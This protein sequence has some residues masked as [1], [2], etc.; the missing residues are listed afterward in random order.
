MTVTTI[1]TA[2]IADNAVDTTQ[3]ADNAVT[4]AKAGFN[5]G[6]I[7]QIVN[8]TYNDVTTTSTSYSR[9]CNCSY[10]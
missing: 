6:K 9:I 10:Y 5:P 7:V 4:A 3:L 8:A 2:G 1:P